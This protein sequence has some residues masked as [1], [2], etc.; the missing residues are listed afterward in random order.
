[1]KQG[2]ERNGVNWFITDDLNVVWIVVE[3]RLDW[4]PM[5]DSKFTLY[6]VTCM[7]IVGMAFLR[8]CAFFISWLQSCVGHFVRCAWNE[9]VPYV[10]YL[11]CN[12]CI[13]SCSYSAIQWYLILRGF[14]FSFLLCLSVSYLQLLFDK[15][16]IFAMFEIIVHHGP[17]IRRFEVAESPSSSNFFPFISNIAIFNSK[18]GWL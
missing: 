7:E 3:C 6:F 2:R 9:D 15:L 17:R 18:G 11:V 16:F 4:N 14:C 10:Q 12:G 8:G 13:L 1:M 5:I